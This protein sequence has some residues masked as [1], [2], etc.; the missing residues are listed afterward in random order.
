MGIGIGNKPKQF[1]SKGW[2]TRPNR[3]CDMPF[4]TTGQ[5]AYKDA[6]RR[7]SSRTGTP[8][9]SLLASFI[10]LHEITAV[11]PFF[12]AFYTFRYFRAG[13]IALNKI[14]ELSQNAHSTRLLDRAVVQA[15][16]WMKD[17]EAWVCR[18]GSRYGVWG[19]EKRDPSGSRGEEFSRIGGAAADAMLAY[20]VTKVSV[21][22]IE[23]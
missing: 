11:V 2:V 3:A 5:E 22:S 16:D 12:S 10:V 23:S 15:N 7:I 21:L 13:E 19:I 9:P 6:L 20:V 17:G 8:L 18:V 4:K 1:N 14:E